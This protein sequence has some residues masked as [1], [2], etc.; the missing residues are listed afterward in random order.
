LNFHKSFQKI[1][2]LLSIA[3]YFSVTDWLAVP[4]LWTTICS[5]T[6]HMRMVYSFLY[7]PRNRSCIS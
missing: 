1:V 7:S 3:H 6:L 2:L 4:H 5:C